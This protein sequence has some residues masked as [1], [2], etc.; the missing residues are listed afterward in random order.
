M[1]RSLMITIGR[2]TDGEKFMKEIN[3]AYLRRGLHW[4]AIEGKEEF[5][6]YNVEHPFWFCVYTKNEFNPVKIMKKIWK[7]NDKAI[8][9]IKT[10]DG[11]KDKFFLNDKGK[12]DYTKL[13]VTDFEPIDRMFY[14]D[15]VQG[16]EV[17]GKHIGA[18][19]IKDKK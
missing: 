14:Q 10:G 9:Y 3:M 4:I 13:K 18:G 8:I 2:V 6:K 19:D 12:I 1:H 17:H 11:P 5:E 7:K 15:K 16:C